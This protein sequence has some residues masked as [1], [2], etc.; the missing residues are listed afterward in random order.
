MLLVEMTR[1]DGMKHMRDPGVRAV[2][3]GACSG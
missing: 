3:G 2:E 1:F